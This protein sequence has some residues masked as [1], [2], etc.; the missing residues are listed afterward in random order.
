[1]R[2]ILAA[3]LISCLMSGGVLADTFG[4]GGNQFDIEFVDI[5]SSTNPGGLGFVDYDYRMGT[6][7]ITN[8]QWDKFSSSLPAPVTGY[9]SGAYD[10]EPYWEGSNVPTTNISWFEAAQ[11]V[12]W[13]NTSSGY[14]AAYNFDSGR[15]GPDNYSLYPWDSEDAWDDSTRLRH[16]DAYYFLPTEDEWVKAAY[17]NGS[18][19]QTYSNA[20]E[21]DLVS[22]ISPDPD[23]WNYWPT[24]LSGPWDIGSGVEELNG[25]FDMMGNVSEWMEGPYII[26]DNYRVIRGG[27]YEDIDIYL[28]LSA[29]TT[30]LPYDELINVG[31]RVA[32]VPEPGSLVLI[33]LGGLAMKKT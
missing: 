10:Q 31:F 19:R 4:S 16:K 6:Y 12:N 21:S 20:S 9:P 25:T 18:K 8:H 29:K 1:M 32:S 23:K 3:I 28:R 5:S 11:F 22:L 13:L 26:Y 30:G 7:E 17:W 14:H 24:N 33:G 27:C 15:G 2:T